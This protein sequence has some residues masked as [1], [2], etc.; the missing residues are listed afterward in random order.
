MKIATW[1]GKFVE[2][3][4]LCI[5]SLRLGYYEV[6]YIL[7]CLSFYRPVQKIWCNFK[8]V[9][10]LFLSTVDTQ[11]YITFRCTTVIQHL[12]TLC[13]YT[14]RCSCYLSLCNTITISLLIFPMLC[15]LFL[16]FIHSVTGSL[17]VPFPFTYFAYTPFPCGNNQFSVF[18]GLIVLFVCFCMCF[19][20]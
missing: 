15:L 1:S 4:I 9:L 7:K 13:C 11:C 6:K 14:H 12:Y 8:T 17:Y 5:H 18:I 10:F 3:F 16:W 19:V 2:G 20:F